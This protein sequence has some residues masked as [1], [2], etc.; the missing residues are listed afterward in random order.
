MLFGTQ[1]VVSEPMVVGD[2]GGKVNE[3]LFA[4]GVGTR[5]V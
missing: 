5:C 2:K 1:Q 3:I 4:I